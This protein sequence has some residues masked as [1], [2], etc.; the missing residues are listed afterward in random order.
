MEV[1][2]KIPMPNNMGVVRYV[3][4]LSVVIAHVNVLAGTSVYWPIS[5]YDAVGG[6]FALSGFLIYGSYLRRPDLKSYL[7]SRCRR[8]L[9]AYWTTVVLFA[10]IF[11]FFST[12][13]DYFLNARF[14]KYMAANLSFMNFAE[15][16]LPGVLE[17]AVSPAVNGSLW[18]MKVEWMLYLSVPIAAVVL[19]KCRRPVFTIAVI[20]VL[21]VAYRLIFS[22]LYGKTGNV[23]YQ[24]LSRQVFG[25]LMFFYTGVLIYYYF[26]TFMRYKY[27]VFGVS[28]VV[29][30]VGGT[31]PLFSVVVGPFAVSM[32]VL[33]FSM[34]GKWGTWEGRH[35]NV[36]YNIYLV[37][38][39]II[40][41]FVLLGLPGQLGDGWFM[42]AVIAASFALSWVMNRVVERPFIR[43]R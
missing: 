22:Y 26:D 9:P 37:H 39:P 1:P 6:F 15:P 11:S 36:S 40:Q 23:A 38:F 5:S 2:Y 32:L 31:F 4:A 8:L 14:W 42:A 19:R 25:Q 13:G 27:V 10:L 24:I 18:T 16:S 33:W 20:Y 7:L 41:I 30:A 34:V 3:L 17:G 28:A 12:S 35:D 43:R 29:V 21:S